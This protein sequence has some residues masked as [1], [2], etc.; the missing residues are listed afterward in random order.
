MEQ[1]TIQTSQN[2]GIVQAYASI[3]ERIT[4][5]IIDYCIMG[6]YLFATL[7]IGGLSKSGF[8]II[9]LGIPVLVYHLLFETFMNGQSPGKSVMKIRVVSENGTALSFTNIFIRWVFRLI[10]ITIS[11]GSIATIFIISSKKKQRIGDL[12]AGTIL[13]RTKQKRSRSLFV[14]LPEDYAL[15][16][17][18]VSLLNEKDIQVVNEVLD[19]LNSSK[20]NEESRFYAYNAKK[21]LVDKMG[22]DTNQKAFEFLETI[23]RD[24]NFLNK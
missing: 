18:Q 1:F 23:M 15:V 16:Y 2:V 13:I 5:A 22:I 12:T 10:D 9:I 20:M 21:R 8:G 3:G 4:A 7:V 11:L 14:E 17:P 6:T 24:Y 19:F